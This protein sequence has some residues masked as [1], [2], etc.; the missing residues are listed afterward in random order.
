MWVRS[1]SL[2]LIQS[3]ALRCTIDPHGHCILII[4]LV[5]FLS[6]ISFTSYLKT[7]SLRLGVFAHHRRVF[8]I[9]AVLEAAGMSASTSILGGF[10]AVGSG[11]CVQD[12]DNQSL[13][14]PLN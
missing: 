5:P 10:G 13:I 14:L 2:I 1:E 6:D 12:S 9:I 11:A 8:S 3:F 7:K 4:S